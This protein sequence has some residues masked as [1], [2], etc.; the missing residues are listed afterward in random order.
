MPKEPF[1]RL[2][3]GSPLRNV[4]LPLC[5]LE[6]GDIW[7]DPQGKHRVGVLDACKPDHLRRL[8]TNDKTKLVINDPPYNIELGG[9][10]TSGLFQI[11]SEAYIDFSRVWLE[12]IVQYME[13]DSHLYIWMGADQSKGFQ[14]LPEFMLMM[15]DF[16]ELKSRSFI[17]MRNQRGYG[18]QKN[19]MAVRQELL[20]YTKGSPEFDVQ[21]TDIPKVLKGYYKKVGGS[22]TENSQRSRSPFIR[23]GNVWIDIQQVF[24]RMKEN[25][26]GAYAQKP[27]KAIERLIE[28]S[29]R[30][31][32]IVTDLFAHSEPP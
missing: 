17:T 8:M 21:Y 29:S 16:E 7:E 1:P 14:P 22:I 3:G 12:N 6:T 30:K 18:T 23:P 26:P 9:R 15:R 31:N 24:Y 28:S 27:L 11:G 25:V 19:W 32:D 4:L 2:D 20:Y 10:N 5:R 13:K